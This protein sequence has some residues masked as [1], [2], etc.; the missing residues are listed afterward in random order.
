M[1][2]RSSLKA[3]T[4]AAPA[5]QV[6]LQVLLRLLPPVPLLQV[7]PVLVLLALPALL[8][9]LVQL[10]LLAVAWAS[11]H[12]GAPAPFPPRRRLW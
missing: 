4:A 7:P 10:G 11:A 9:L 1:H 6:L 3:P 12:R 2:D 5:L 8:L